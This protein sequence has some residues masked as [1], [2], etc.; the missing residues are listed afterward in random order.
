MLPQVANA[1]LAAAD[2]F[3]GVE[4]FVTEQYAAERRFA[5][6]VATDQAD[7]LIVGQ[8]AAGAVEQILVTVAL[9]G[10][11]QLEDDGHRWNGGGRTMKDKETRRRG[12]KET[13]GASRFA[14]SRCLPV[15]KSPCLDYVEGGRIRQPMITT[16]T[17]NAKQRPA[18]QSP[19]CT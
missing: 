13:L 4:L 14:E 17:L 10:I 9:M 18:N 1:E 7:L 5:G 3:A 15:S 8:G 16:R 2:D 11:D 12:D 19:Y 6:A